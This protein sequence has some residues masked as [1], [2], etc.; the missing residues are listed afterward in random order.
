MLLA[1]VVFAGCGSKEP[2]EGP[3]D[4]NHTEEPQNPSGD[5]TD[6]DD[7][8]D[9]IDPA[10]Q[11]PASLEGTKWMGTV[12]VVEDGGKYKYNMQ[13]T[14]RP[15]MMVDILMGEDD[16]FED[17]ES[18]SVK[19]TYK[20][21]EMKAVH[22]H[23]DEDYECVHI[24]ECIVQSATT[25]HLKYSG[26]NTLDDSASPENPEEFFQMDLHRTN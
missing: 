1:S 2:A 19:Y 17:G 20:A 23:G 18:I 6:R 15:G 3:D 4:G 11:I 12:E 16:D 14:F 8:N 21:P 10:P 7:D 22:S 26:Y 24:F 9:Q 5:N 13:F 25:M